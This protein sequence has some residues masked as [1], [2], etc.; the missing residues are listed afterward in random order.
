MLAIKKDE[1]KPRLF[2]NRLYSSTDVS[3]PPVHFKIHP[4][5]VI[6]NFKGLFEI[7]RDIRTLTFQISRIEK[8]YLTTKHPKFICDLTPLHKILT[9][10]E[11]GEIAPEEQFSLYPHFFLPVVKFLC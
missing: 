9:I 5:L 3:L 2:L 11:K 7:H 8:K 1:V 4:A 6:S 10:V